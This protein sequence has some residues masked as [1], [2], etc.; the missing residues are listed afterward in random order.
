MSANPTPPL[1]VTGNRPEAKSYGVVDIGPFKADIKFAQGLWQ[2]CPHYNNNPR[3]TAAIHMNAMIRDVG[4]IWTVVPENEVPK[5]EAVLRDMGRL[6]RE[7][8]AD[9]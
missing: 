8:S 1:S 5:L 2:F 4:R 9:V 7:E 6:R 3:D